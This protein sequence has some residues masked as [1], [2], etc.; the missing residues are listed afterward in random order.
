V[1][2]GTNLFF[3][4]GVALIVAGVLFVISRVPRRQRPQGDHYTTALNQLIHDDYDAA[5]KSLRL[6]IESGHTTPDAYIKLG[7]LLLRR[8]DHNAAFQ[9]HHNL[10]VRT[11]LDEATR[12]QVLRCLVRDHQALGRHADAL[13]TL[14]QLAAH[15]RGEPGIHWEIAEEALASG[16]YDTAVSALREAQKTDERVTAERAAAFL[17]RVG[18]RCLRHHL[19][20]D[21]E[22]FFK[23]AL[24]E[25][26]H[27][28][29]ALQQLGDMS[30]EDGDHETALFYWQKL[31]FAAAPE[32]PE[33]HER[34]EKVYFDLGRFGDIERVY[35][36]ILDKR[37][38]DL[39]TLLAFAR[40]ATKKGS[41]E[42]AERLLLQAREVAP[43][44]PTAFQLLA[45]LYLDQS[46]VQETRELI[47]RFAGRQRR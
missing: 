22:R 47:S 6:A 12:V 38:Q 8:G 20:Q 23:Q 34:L 1:P 18:E 2:A 10:T 42:E 11:D 39:Q 13:L 37:P 21:A 40:I 17:S 9:I 41:L 24:K 36:Q 26:T 14:Q 29:P 28:A 31:I 19:K 25:D 32:G 4:I 30:Y 45:D 7:S 35:A 3:W 44:D 27:C 43:Q 15:S 16:E 5:L 33:L 46:K